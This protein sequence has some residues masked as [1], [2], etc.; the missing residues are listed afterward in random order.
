MKIADHIVD[1]G[2]YAG[3]NGGKIVVSGSYED[4]VNCKE[5]ITGQYLSGERKIE[6]PQ[7]RRVGN[8][9]FLTIKGCKHK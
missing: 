9:E 3:V 6:V 5:S 4:V 7:N 1:I 8:G 2:K